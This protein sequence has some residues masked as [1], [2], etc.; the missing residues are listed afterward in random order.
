[1]TDDLTAAVA[2]LREQ[3]ELV[4]VGDLVSTVLARRTDLRLVL[5]ALEAAQADA[6]RGRDLHK[7]VSDH[8]YCCYCDK[9]PARPVRE[10]VRAIDAAMGDSDALAERRRP[11]KGDAM[12]APPREPVFCPQRKKPCI[13]G[14]PYPSECPEPAPSAELAEAERDALRECVKAADVVRVECARDS[15][16]SYHD[17]LLD[18]VVAYDR[19]R[20]K[21]KP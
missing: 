20:A 10:A 19:A 8:W 16:P 6:L 13:A 3:S 4:G 14:C 7:A 5:A 12:T 18:S 11:R 9:G 17:R 1:M 21:V 15:G 2:R